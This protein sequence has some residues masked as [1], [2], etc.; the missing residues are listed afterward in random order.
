M[1]RRL[2]RSAVSPHTVHKLLD[3]STSQASRRMFQLSGVACAGLPMVDNLFESQSH[4]CLQ[5]DTQQMT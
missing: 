2:Y 4:A 3:R 1:D 5:N